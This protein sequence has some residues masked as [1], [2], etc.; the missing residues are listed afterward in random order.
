M[1]LQKRSTHGGGS[2]T[3]R[4]RVGIG[5]LVLLLLATGYKQAQG[6][7]DVNV[8]Q[9]IQTVAA[10]KERSEPG[11]GPTIEIT[12]NSSREFPVR[13]EIVILNIGGKEFSTSRSPADGS[14]DTLIFLVGESDWAALRNADPLVVYFG[15]DDP[16]NPETRW[17]FGT[18]N[19]SLLDKP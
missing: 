16:K 8:V 3:W 7:A 17:D 2:Q 13:N 6:A 19:K 18:L 15:Q 14:L 12:I 1:S 10:T 11:G 4:A 9:S 5:L